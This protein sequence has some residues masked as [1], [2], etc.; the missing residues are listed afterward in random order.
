MS[1][2]LP[3]FVGSVTPQDVV[4]CEAFAAADACALR[5]PQLAA[6]ATQA[7]VPLQASHVRPQ[8]LRA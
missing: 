4:M 7:Q 1:A 5:H 6:A 3:T 2:L 8:C